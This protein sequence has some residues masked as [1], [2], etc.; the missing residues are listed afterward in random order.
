MGIEVSCELLAQATSLFSG[1]CLCVCV[2]AR[3][4]VRTVHILVCIGQGSALG[5]VPQTPATLFFD[6]KSLSG[7]ELTN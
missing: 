6:T 7:L 5:V 2:Y 3:T 1:V 4:R